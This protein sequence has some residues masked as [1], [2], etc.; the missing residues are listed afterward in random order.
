M[1]PLAPLLPRPCRPIWAEVT[2]LSPKSSN[3]QSSTGRLNDSHLVTLPGVLHDLTT[4][5]L[6]IFISVLPAGKRGP[7]VQFL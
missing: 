4:C 3:D 7:W 2:E 5:W 1:A 6:N